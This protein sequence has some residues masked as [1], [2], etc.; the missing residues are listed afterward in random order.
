ME[1]PD[2][3]ELQ[4]EFLK[5]VSDFS[6][7]LLTAWSETVKHS[8]I[9]QSF[10]GLPAPQFP[11]P[12]FQTLYG[13]AD[14]A[15]TATKLGE[16]V[17]QFMGD[18]PEV[19]RC[20]GDAS[21]M[22]RVKERWTASQQRF[23]RQMLGIPAPSEAEHLL[24][25]WRRVLGNLSG[26]SGRPTGA[27]P[28]L[29]GSSWMGGW[30]SVPTAEP[31]ADTMRAWNEVYQ[32]M[33]GSVFPMPWFWPTE[34]LEERAKKAVDAQITFLQSLPAFQEQIAEVATKSVAKIIAQ[35][36]TMNVKDLTP[37]IYRA[38]FR[39][40][41][42]NQQDAFQE[43]LASESFRD[44]MTTAAKLSLE[45]TKNMDAVAP[46]CPPFGDPVLKKDLDALAEEMQKM[47]RRLRLVEREV[48]DLKQG[49]RRAGLKGQPE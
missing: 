28:F 19:V 10:G 27:M 21:R 32:R 20:L 23:V 29:T 25:Q 22:Q 38:L 11:G 43:L 18:L 4:E 13:G 6:A 2:F 46:A 17:S 45:A 30:P 34:G 42:T 9:Q 5:S 16:M 33:V 36:E 49:P 26:A 35:I 7:A 40:W 12:G 39:V 48:E 41:L 44:A 8:G 31:P 37:K 3:A 1:T 24:E 15:L 14:P 47:E